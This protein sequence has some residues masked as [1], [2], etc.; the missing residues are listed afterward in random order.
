MTTHKKS[1]NVLVPQ[2]CG[3]VQRWMPEMEDLLG[4]NRCTT[5][6]SQYDESTKNLEVQLLSPAEIGNLIAH[7]SVHVSAL[8]S[9][10]NPD[11]TWSTEAI[12]T[13]CNLPPID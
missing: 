9:Y 6:Q 12:C 1:N 7:Y 2:E 13:N 3:C 4:T 11:G 8:Y 5:H 10:Q